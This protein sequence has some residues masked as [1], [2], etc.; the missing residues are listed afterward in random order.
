MNGGWKPSSRISG[1]DGLKNNSPMFVTSYTTRRR[2]SM[3]KLE[4]TQQKLGL[5]HS[6][7]ARV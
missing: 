5:F 7:T 6:V 4:I 2:L 1:A 3:E